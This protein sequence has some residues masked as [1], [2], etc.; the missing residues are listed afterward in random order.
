MNDNTG[1][2]VNSASWIYKTKP[3]GE[4][5]QPDFLNASV[6]IDTIMA[7]TELLR[8]CLD[9]ENSMG[10]KRKEK[11]GPRLIDI[12]ILLFSDNILNEKDI[13]IPH[14]HMHERAFVL[15]PLSDIAPDFRHP[16]LDKTVAELLSAVDTRGIAQTGKRLEI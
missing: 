13:I 3:V 16:L 5:S 14:P 6:G 9:I 4:L 8:A 12:D 10:R 1:I 2:H 15:A 7:V 11:W